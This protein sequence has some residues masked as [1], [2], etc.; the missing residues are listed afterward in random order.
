VCVDNI[1]KKKGYQLRYPSFKNRNNYYTAG[2][3]LICV[4]D[5]SAVTAAGV[6]K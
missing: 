3:G 1:N 5:A 4:A 2:V 6:T